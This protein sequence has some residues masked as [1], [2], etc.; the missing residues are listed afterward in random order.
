MRG[1]TLKALATA[2]LVGVFFAQETRAIAETLSGNFEALFEGRKNRYHKGSLVYGGHRFGG[3]EMPFSLYSRFTL[4]DLP[5]GASAVAY[6]RYRDD[7]AY[8][9]Y[10]DE[11]G[12]VDVFLGYVEIPRIADRLSLVLGRQFIHKA[13]NVFLADAIQGDL[14]ITKSLALNFFYGKP[15][16]LETFSE[17]YNQDE[18]IDEKIWGISAK[19]SLPFQIS[20][21][22]GYMERDLDYP[23]EHDELL[24]LTWQKPLSFPIDSLLYQEMVYNNSQGGF[25]D[26]VFGT[27][28]FLT[29]KFSMK[30]E[31]TYYDTNLWERE[32]YTTD[33]FTL[34][35]MDDLIFGL[36]SASSLWQSKVGFDYALNPGLSVYT[37]FAYQTYETFPGERTKGYS[38][39]PG[40]RKTFGERNE[41]A[42]SLGMFYLKSY[43]GEAL[44]PRAEYS[45]KLTQRLEWENWFNMVHYDKTTN[46]SDQAFN[47][48]T[49]VSYLLFRDCKLQGF[50]EANSND[51]YHDD[52]RGGLMAF[53]NF[54]TKF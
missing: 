13:G 44:G 32:A 2:C 8:N 29:Q 7:F 39:E 34:N 48:R 54:D 1:T 51:F 46:Q 27:Q 31:G 22:V 20:G 12:Q 10:P 18:N 30:L 47:F 19:F 11:S 15:R 28:M 38:F 50:F 33:M 35:T 9:G 26:V 49:M 23:D 53:Y 3:N 42:L 43:G 52:I 41:H 40:L 24:H 37:D 14:E 6:F 4:E 45:L 17:W 21:E 5:Q 16:D 36:F 25:E